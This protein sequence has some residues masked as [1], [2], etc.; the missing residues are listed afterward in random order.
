MGYLGSDYSWEQSEFSYPDRAV[1]N[2]SNTDTPVLLRTFLQR[3]QKWVFEKIDIR[4]WL[5]YW[6]KSSGTHF[7]FW[8]ILPIPLVNSEDSICCS[9]YHKVALSHS[10]YS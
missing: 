10:C 9:A 1:Y 5:V 2:A 8:A 7:I 6:M 3:I 4:I